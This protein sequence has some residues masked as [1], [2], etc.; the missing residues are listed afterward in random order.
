MRATSVQNSSQCSTVNIPKAQPNKKERGK[1]RTQKTSHQTIYDHRRSP[2]VSKMSKKRT[3][4][5]PKIMQKICQNSYKFRSPA[6]SNWPVSII[7]R[8]TKKST[9]M[10]GLASLFFFCFPFFGSFFF[11]FSKHN[12]TLH[13][14]EIIENQELRHNVAAPQKLTIYIYLFSN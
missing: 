10:K 12:T 8:V 13:F 3:Q 6:E 4:S 2:G 11:A 14:F 7:S 9:V 5:V 1:N